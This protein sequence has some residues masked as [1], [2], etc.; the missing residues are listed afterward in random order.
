MWESIRTEGY[1]EGEVWNKRKD[2]QIYLQRLTIT[3]VKNQ[4]GETTHYVGDGQD[5]TQAKQAAADRAA[6]DAARK[7]QESRWSPEPPCVPGFDMAGAAYPA[8]RVSGD[9]FDFGSLG[10]GLLGVLVADVTGHGLGPALVMAQIQAYMRALCDLHNDPA[11]LVTHVNRLF[12]SNRSDHLVTLF[13]GR[14]DVGTSSF[15]YAGAGHQGYIISGNDEVTVLESTS[16]PLGVAENLTASSAPAIV[17]NPGD[18]IVLPTDGIEETESSDG[19]MFGR[20]RIFDVVRA[21]RDKS[22]AE[23]VE[24]LFLAAR[25]FAGGERQK[26]DITAVVVKMLH[27]R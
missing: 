25:G 19:R 23:I 22:A 10:K 8:E 26:D 12:A 3:C 21:N 2:S 9:Y 16:L 17:L 24:A 4:S 1:W 14:L 27:T 5:I 7:V 6:I 20:D 18:I 15:I 11:V 13:L